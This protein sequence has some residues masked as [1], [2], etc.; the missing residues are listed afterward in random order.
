MISGMAIVET[1][2]SDR[3]TSGAWRVKNKN[4]VSVSP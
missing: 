2:I 1:T 4:D 3:A